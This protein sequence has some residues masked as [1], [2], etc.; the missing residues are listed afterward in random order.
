MRERMTRQRMLEVARGTRELI[1]RHIERESAGAADPKVLDG[2]EKL[3]AENE[4]LIRNLGK[5]DGGAL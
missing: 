4:E 5:D 2:L 1:S 3:L